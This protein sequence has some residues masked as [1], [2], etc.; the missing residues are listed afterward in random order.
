MG[1]SPNP[2]TATSA[3]PARCKAWTSAIVHRVVAEKTAVGAFG[4]SR[5]FT[6]SAAHSSADPLG[7]Q[8]RSGRPSSP[9]SATA[10][11]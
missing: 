6:S 9:S 1:K 2:T 8:I 10:D 11:R 4:A 3:R 5:S 7:M